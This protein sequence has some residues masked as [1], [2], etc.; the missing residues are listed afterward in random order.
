[1]KRWIPAPLFPLLILFLFLGCSTG[2]TG[3]G[4]G[5]DREPCRPA[6]NT[7][8]KADAFR[9]FYRERTQRILLSLNRFSLSGDAVAA[10]AFSNAAIA[11]SGDEWEVVSGPQ[12]NNPFGKTLFST[13]KLYQAMG[14]RDLELT[15]IRMFEGIVFNEAVSGHPGITTREAFPGWRRV[16]DGGNRMV[17]RTRWGV[18]VIPPVSYPRVLEQEILETFFNGVVFT[19]RENPGEHFFSFMPA[20]NTG[21]Y[22]VTYVFDELHHDPPFLRQ[23]DCCSSFMVS[24]LGPWRGAYWG[25]HNSRDNFTDYAMGFLAAFEA[26]ATP[27][28][29]ADLALAAQNAADAARRT[30][31]TVLAHGNILMTV[32]EWH[33]YDT[34]SPAGGMNPDG[35][36]EWQD[37]GSLSSCLMAYTAH[38]VSTAGLSWPVPETPLPGAVETS[39][40]RQLFRDLGLPPPPLPVLQCKSL[41]D[42]FVGQTWRD[43]LDA[44]IFG[45]PLWEVADLIAELDPDLFPGLL[46]GMMDDFT[47]M[48]LGAVLLCYYAQTAGDDALFS[49]ARETLGNLIGF[50]RIL[51]RLVYPAAGDPRIIRAI[52]PEAAEEVIRAANEMIYRGAVYAR[53][54][55]FDSS[56]EDLDAFARGEA[57]ISHLEAYLKM[58]D[59]QE[60]ALITDQEIAAAVEGKL[61]ATMNRAPWRVERYRERFGETYPVRRAGDGYECIGTD[62][63][64]R[65]TENS[66]HDPFHIKSIGLWF[67]APLCIHSPETLD[68]TWAKWGCAPA[69]LDGSGEVDGEDVSL[70]EAAWGSH[71]CGARCNAGNSGCGGADLDGSGVLSEEDQAY[72]E[73]AQG[74]TTGEG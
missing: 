6:S 33:D 71:G 1:M 12:D 42:A 23:S 5:D 67:E 44:E 37:L 43:F 64:W 20:H 53:L 49:E 65:P 41:D 55:G 54:F 45:I 32:D 11:K 18:P 10:N 73:A 4:G 56:A 7:E 52:G 58:N 48:M 27:G 66:R 2:G 61:A 31:D 28:L 34:L 46:G 38:A 30:G 21:S 24:Q 50:Q 8:A 68:C 74:C 17:T 62:D 63:Q 9:L 60:R 69:D 40:I 13:W 19:Y 59:T 39:W 22:A 36:V 72:I 47:E 51:A 29:P 3:D 35:E 70:F 16:M 14:G 15:L 26:E 57:S 25:N